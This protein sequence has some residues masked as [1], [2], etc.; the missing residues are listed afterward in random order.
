M[1]VQNNKMN[2][3]DPEK[4]YCFRLLDGTKVYAFGV[5][6]ASFDAA[7]HKKVIKL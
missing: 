5:M 1:I 6:I 3:L 7:Q 2:H 4:V